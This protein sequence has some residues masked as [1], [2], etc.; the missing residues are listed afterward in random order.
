[1]RCI[2]TKSAF[3]FSIFNGFLAVL[4]LGGG[5][6]EPKNMV[7]TVSCAFPVFISEF[8]RLHSRLH[9]SWN[10]RPD[11]SKR[12][13]SHDPTTYCHR[14]MKRW[15][16]RHLFRRMQSLKCMSRFAAVSRFP[17]ICSKLDCAQHV[18]DSWWPS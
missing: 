7:K 10:L 1:M 11:V 16:F 6:L 18:L 12:C 2:R 15:N 14:A 9:S 4:F 3:P 17:K 8:P 5:L 13:G